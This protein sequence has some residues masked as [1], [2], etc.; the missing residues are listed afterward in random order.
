MPI[1]ALTPPQRAALLLLLGVTSQIGNNDLKERY[2][3]TLTGK[4]KKQLNDLK[5]VVSGKVAGFGNQIFHELDEPG[6]ARAREEL[7]GDLPT[8]LWGRAV[9]LSTA[10]QLDRY[11]RRADLRLHDVFQAADSPEETAA[12]E[13][14]GLPDRIRAAYWEITKKPNG[15]VLLSALREQFADVSRA[16]LDTALVA[17]NSAPDVSF[18]TET[19]KRS[20]ADGGAGAVTIGNQKKHLIAIEGA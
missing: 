10:E 15:W 2:G 16:D 1:D 12:A 13:P 7:T 19:N 18:S 8:G 9:A 20:L 3:V 14:V 17:L 6:W 11:L 4:D 5:L